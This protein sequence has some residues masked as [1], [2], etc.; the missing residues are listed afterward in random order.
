MEFQQEDF[1]YQDLFSENTYLHDVLSHYSDPKNVKTIKTDLESFSAKA[2]TDLLPLVWQA[3][4]NQPQLIQYD[5]WGKRIDHIEVD[6]AWQAL[7]K[8]SANEGIVAIGYERQTGKDSRLHQFLKLMIFHPS[9][10]FYSCPLAMTDGATRVLELE[11]GP[12]KKAYF[13]NLI[14]R[15]E[16]RFW[17]AGQWMTEKAG[18]SDVSQSETRA[19]EKDGRYFLYG[20]KWFTSAITANLA[21]ALA[22]TN[23][24]GED[25][26][27][28]FA[29]RI[30]D[31]KGHLNNIEVLRLKDK[32]GTKAMPTAELSLKGA[33]GFLIGEKGR[34]VK[35]ITTILN[36]S[37]LYNS[38]CATGTIYRLHSLLRDYSKKRFAFGKKLIDHPLH[39]ETLIKTQAD[40]NACVHFICEM[41]TLLGRSEVSEATEMEK[42]ALR[43]LTPVAKLWTGKKAVANVSEMIE[44]FGGAGYI[45]DTQLPRFL[46]DA[47]VFPIWEGTTNIM[48]LDTLRAMSKGQVFEQSITYLKTYLQ[49]CNDS[50]EKQTLLQLMNA[51]VAWV[52]QNQKNHNVLESGA[53]QLA[54][55]LGDLFAGVLMLRFAG[56]TKKQR[57]HHLAHV[58]IGQIQFPDFISQEKRSELN[59][60]TL[61]S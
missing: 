10:A 34:G 57:D 50:K 8:V 18:G 17:T 40:T 31:D 12:L 47:Q 25:R 41:A 56:R 42:A 55:S 15:H 5:H 21:M 44:G 38:V 49:D 54:F 28:L 2:C 23:V 24:E 60:Q 3:E 4:K 11:D 51:C 48:S 27:S 32:L 19:E 26:L 53:R 7:H 9:S 59:K 6:P 52:S 61:L 35:M 45:E 43:L 46:R 37:R 29:I 30:R 22:Q 39:Q 33:E 14:S 20:T 36:I 1:V 16:D 13:P 58:F